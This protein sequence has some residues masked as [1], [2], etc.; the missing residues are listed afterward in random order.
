MINM[1]N[2]HSNYSK[3]HETKQETTGIKESKLRVHENE[4]NRT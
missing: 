1:M 2:L 3:W 4:T